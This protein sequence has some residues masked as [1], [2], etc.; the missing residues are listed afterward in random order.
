MNRA[1]N[2]LKNWFE[3]TEID[4]EKD[5]AVEHAKWTNEKMTK[6]KMIRDRKHDRVQRKRK[7]VYWTELGMNVG[8]ELCETHFCVVIKEFDTH[9]VV[10]PL[11][12]VKADDQESNWKTEGNGFYK[13]GVLD[14]LPR[15]KKETYAV[16]SQIRT[17]S[18]KRL[19]TYKDSVS[20]SYIHMKLRDPQM[21]IID[22]AIKEL[23]TVRN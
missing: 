11:S 8:S 6:N 20:G 12:S 17:V 1:K 2:N 14:D 15:D 19:T 13:I 5:Y 16:V 18:K 21:D 9:A 23:F 4:E 7:F 3:N 10:I 22:K